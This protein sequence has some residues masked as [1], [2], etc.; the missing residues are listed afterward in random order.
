MKSITELD[1]NFALKQYTARQNTTVYNVLEKPFSLHG[2]IPPQNSE[3]VFRR[4]PKDRAA[5]VS[6]AVTLLH[7]HCAGGRVRF[8]TDSSYI[9]IL[10]QLGEKEVM[11]FFALTGSTGFDLHSGLKHISTFRPDANHLDELF[12][13]QEVAGGTMQDYTLS[14]PLYSGVRQVQVI[15]DADARLEAA[16]PYA[17]QKPVVFYGSS[18]T[19]GG[20]ASRPGTSYSAILSRRMDFEYVN[21][22]FSGSALGEPAMA[23]YIAELDMSAFVLDYDHNAPNAEHLERTHE[24]LFQKVR[25][26]HPEI[27]ILCLNKPF[28]QGEPDRDAIIQRTVDNARRQGDK[29][30]Y[31]LNIDQWLKDAGIQHEATVDRCHPNDLGFYYMAQAVEE[32]LKTVL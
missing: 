9:A 10:A 21:L 27:P 20:C 2:L 13:E 1:K 18:I 25:A 24:P 14:F 23:E 11:P 30:A 29:N 7:A 32:L 26:A 15:L 19:Q 22:G 12:G 17:V 6:K 4:M 8:R 16:T 31:F 5:A 3:D 28:F